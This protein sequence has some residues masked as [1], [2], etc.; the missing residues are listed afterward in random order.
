MRRRPF[1]NWR[2]VAKTAFIGSCLAI[3]I[4]LVGWAFYQW[5]GARV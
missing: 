4:G 1:I 2:E 5:V 3:A